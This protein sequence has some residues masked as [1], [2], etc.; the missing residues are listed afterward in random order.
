MITNLDLHNLEEAK[1]GRRLSH[2][3]GGVIFI[4]MNAVHAAKVY[5]SAD[6]IGLK[7]LSPTMK[8]ADRV[9]VP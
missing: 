2:N 7:I 4:P 3:P 8:E 9:L 1:T 6:L 5:E